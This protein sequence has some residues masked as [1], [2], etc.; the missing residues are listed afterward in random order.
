[1]YKQSPES[2][3]E[4]L[5]L[6]I[7]FKVYWIMIFQAC[8]FFAVFI[9]AYKVFSF[10][11]DPIKKFWVRFLFLSRCSLPSFSSCFFYSSETLDDILYFADNDLFVPNC[12]GSGILRKLY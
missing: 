2:F 9:E 11:L 6:G 7:D 3:S 4:K 12:L 10:Y 8:L 1:M 5:F